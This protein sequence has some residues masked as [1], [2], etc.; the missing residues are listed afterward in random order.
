MPWSSLCLPGLDNLAH[1]DMTDTFTAVL[2][3]LCSMSHVSS[4]RRCCEMTKEQN[5]SSFISREIL[6]GFLYRQ[7]GPKTV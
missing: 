6:I 1:P 7:S 2:L 5:S 3:T 4:L